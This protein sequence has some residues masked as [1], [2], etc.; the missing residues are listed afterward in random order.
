MDGRVYQPWQEAIEREVVLP[1]Y[2]VEALG[3][4]LVPDAF[5][6]PAEKQFEHVARQH[7]TDRWCD[8][9]RTQ[10]RSAARSKS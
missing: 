6:F 9:A 10:E 5:S 8:H 1:V 7:W 3:Y 2:N 4:R